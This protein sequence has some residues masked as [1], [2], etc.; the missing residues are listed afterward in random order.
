MKSFKINKSEIP[1]I[2]SIFLTS[3]V[4]AYAGWIMVRPW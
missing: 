4:I 3:S 2:I 1:M